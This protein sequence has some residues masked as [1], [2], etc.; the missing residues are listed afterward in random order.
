MQVRRRGEQRTFEEVLAVE[1]AEMPG[2]RK[3]TGKDP[4]H[5]LPIVHNSYIERGFYAE[6]L[7]RWFDLFERDRFLILASAEL[8]DDTEGAMATITAFLGVP[9]WPSEKYARLSAGTYEPMAPETREHLARLF[10]PHNRK[11]DE[12]LGRTFEWTRPAASPALLR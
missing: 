10:E 9:E 5:V 3:L 7:E 4:T 6:Q 8:S 11:L 12:L 2:R 1:E